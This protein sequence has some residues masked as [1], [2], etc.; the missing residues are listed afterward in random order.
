MAVTLKD[1]EALAEE[2]L[3]FASALTSDIPVLL[4]WGV[5]RQA[6]F[7]RLQNAEFQLQSGEEE[8]AVKL[9]RQILEADAV[10][11]ARLEKEL[12]V[13][14]QEIIAT[15]KMRQLLKSQ[16]VNSAPV[17]LQRVA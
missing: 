15:N 10:I 13:L 17:L 1:F 7:A 2:S 5:R 11:I 8:G 6:I 3:Q 4:S 14:E 16:S 12:G 9:I